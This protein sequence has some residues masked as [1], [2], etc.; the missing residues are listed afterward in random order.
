MLV[1]NSVF[2]IICVFPIGLFRFILLFMP[3]M[4]AGRRN[5]NFFMT[6]LWLLNISSYINATFNFLIYYTMGSRYRKTLW[7]LPCCRWCWRG[8]THKSKGGK[9]LGEKMDK[10][11]PSA[12]SY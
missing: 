3:E 1:Y 5:H 9:N 6:G 11:K 2:F 10:S 4:N 12:V 7:S 8:K